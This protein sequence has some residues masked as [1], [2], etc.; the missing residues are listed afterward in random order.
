MSEVVFRTGLSRHRSRSGRALIASCQ[1]FAVVGSV[2]LI[3]MAAMSL[4][5]I[6][7]RALIGKPILGDYEL[8]QAICAA[9]VAMTLPYCQLVRGHVIVDFFTTKAS[10]RITR[11]LDIAASLLLAAIGFVVAWR[12]GR[13]ALDLWRTGD[14]SMLIAIPT[15]IPYVPI[16]LSF[17]L[18]GCA[19]LFTAFD[20]IRAGARA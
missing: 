10:P 20:D 1:A 14:A 9:A 19:A 3:L 2:L 13:G 18:L 16:A 15:W 6:A 11:T 8:V 17:A 12:V 7:G 4:A 5:S